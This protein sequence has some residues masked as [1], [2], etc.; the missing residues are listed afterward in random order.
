MGIENSLF[1]K[2]YSR[3]AF[4]FVAIYALSFG[5]AFSLWAQSND[6][7]SS[8]RARSAALARGEILAVEQD[9]AT[10]AGEA[11]IGSEYAVKLARER[12]LPFKSGEQLTYTLGYKWGTINSDVGEGVITTTFADSTFSAVIDGRTTKL[13]DLFFKV[14]EHFETTVSLSTMRPLRFFRESHEGKYSMINKYTFNPDYS[15]NARIIRMDNA[16]QDTLLKGNAYTYDMVSLYFSARC[17][18]FSNVELDSKQPIAFAIDRTIYNLYFVYRGKDVISVKG[19]GKF[20]ALKFNVRLVAGEVFTGDDEMT[21]WVS[22]DSNKIPLLFES[23]ILKGTVYGRLKKF[24]NLAWP[25]S[26]KIK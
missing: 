1:M 13:F 3:F 7:N 10:V 9:T 5:G 18:D 22:D 6:T 2:R 26:S 20:N 11:Y 16:P 15:I 24:S 17:I 14:R 12:R 25:M 21:L 19:I 8:L 23:K 4:L